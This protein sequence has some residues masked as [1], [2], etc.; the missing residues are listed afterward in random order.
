[1]DPEREF[2]AGNLDRPKSAKWRQKAATGSFTHPPW[3]VPGADLLQDRF[4]NA[5][6]HHFFGFLMDFDTLFK[7]FPNF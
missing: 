3:Q 5:P 2:A 1:M 7:D 6:G 4:R